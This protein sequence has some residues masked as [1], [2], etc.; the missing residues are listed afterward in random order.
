MTPSPVDTIRQ[1]RRRL[2][3]L[4]LILVILHQLVN[5]QNELSHLF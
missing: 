3:W 2:T 4:L 1:V 5:V